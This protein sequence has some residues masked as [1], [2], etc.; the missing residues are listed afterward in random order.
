MKAAETKV[1]T[2]VLYRDTVNDRIL[3]GTIISELML[4]PYGLCVILDLDE[5]GGGHAVALIENLYATKKELADDVEKEK[6][7]YVNDVSK[8]INTLEDLLRYIFN[9]A[10]ENNCFESG[11]S[12]NEKCAI[13]T[14]AA[15][16][17]GINLD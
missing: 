16:K 10:K 7:E 11:S 15:E 1:G 6:S 2:K 5:P 14:I 4:S 17:F 3:K 9:I 8:N 13:Q 12:Y